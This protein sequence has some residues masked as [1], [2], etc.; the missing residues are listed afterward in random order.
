MVAEYNLL[1]H[2]SY[3]YPIYTIS[4]TATTIMILSG[5]VLFNFEI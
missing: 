2:L 4:I 1:I 5:F 3:L